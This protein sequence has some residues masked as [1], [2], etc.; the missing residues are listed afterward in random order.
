MAKKYDLVV[1]GAGP[2][3]LM[4]AKTA[5]EYGLSVA[6]LERKKDIPEIRR[7]CA[8]M[9]LVFNEGYFGD[10]MRINRRGGRLCFP[11]NGFSVKYNGPLKNLYAIYGY[12]SKGYQ[13]RFGDCDKGREIGDAAK[14]ALVHDK[15]I[16]LK[17][18]LEEVESAGVEIFSGI[19]VTGIETRGDS[20][21]VRAGS[22]EFTGTFVIAADGVNSLIAQIL[23]FNKNRKFYGMLL[24]RTYHM[25]EVEG[26]DPNAFTMIFYGRPYP[27][28]CALSPRAAGDGFQVI[29]LTFSPAIDPG[30]VFNRL[31]SE[32]FTQSWFKRAKRIR[33]YAAVQNLWEPIIE[34]YKD[35]VLLIS[36]TS[37][38][39]EAEN[40]GSL[41]CGWKAA[42]VLTV[43]LSE[44]KIS[45]EGVEDYLRWWKDSFCIPYDY[46]NY[47]KNYTICN[48]F[49]DE[50]VNY[51]FS[52][53]KE[54]MP[55]SL[56]A[57]ELFN[58]VGMELGKSM[59]KIAIERPELLKKIQT[60]GTAP[61]EELM[62]DAI[63]EGFPNR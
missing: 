42:S 20:V 27:S 59:D 47:L 62:K 36:D 5:G 30:L 22:E 43:A 63:R 21:V 51:L 54:T 15:S 45:R 4:A 26:P 16:L 14:I 23:G 17:G 3:G 12:S 24:S 56:N 49:E 40:T 10:R 6:L 60:F 1:V 39:Q 31:T 34:P 28:L 38:T 61:V 37:W 2:A 35:G 7:A 33:A 41:L 46:R 55:A 18:L 13:I 9:L 50:E 25:T 29:A 48:F 52:N 58:L 44:G 11:K 8:M 19:N 57:Y 32:G 53:I